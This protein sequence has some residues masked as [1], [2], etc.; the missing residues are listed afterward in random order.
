MGKR[1]ILMCAESSHVDSGF[2][3]YTRNLLS[4]LYQTGKYEIAE[5][6]AYRS[7]N[8]KKGFPWRIYP[9]VPFEG[10]PQDVEQKEIVNRYKSNP[11][12]AFG[13][14]AFEAACY[15][16]KPDIVFDVRDFW[17]LNFP[18]VSP[19]RPFFH[20]FVA[21][22][23]D[24]APQ[25][26]EW[27]QTFANADTISGH[28]Q[29]GVDYLA[30]TN[31]GMNLV[32]PVNDAVNT[33]VFLP[34]HQP[35]EIIKQELGFNKDDI[36]IGS[37]MRNQKRKLI[38]N[39]IK[40]AKEVSK[41]VPN[42]K[43]YLHTSYP[44]MN[45]WDLPSLLVEH[46]AMDLVYMTYKCQA[47]GAH[48]ASTFKD[49]NTICHKCGKHA[50]VVCSVS[51]GVNEQELSNIFN[52]FDVYLQYAICEGFGIPPVEAAACGV[53]VV[54]IDHGA[55]AEIGANIG[56]DIIPVASEFRELETNA[57][58]VYPD[59]NKCID[60]LVE[61]CK[62]IPEM[63]FIEKSKVR[64]QTRE[65]LMSNY[66]WD[67]T[68]KTFENILDN[69]KLTGVQGKWDS[70]PQKSRT[71]VKVPQLPSHRKT[72][73]FITNYI[74]NT[75]H[76]TKTSTIQDIIKSLCL[77]YKMNGPNMHPFTFEDAVKSLEGLMHN[78]DLWEQVRIGEIDFPK[79]LEYIIKYPERDHLK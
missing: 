58:R 4:R 63:S 41:Q 18:E 8:M 26:K 75:P 68:A 67:K 27:L 1:R 43:L 38:P 39:V 28:T 19:F 30:S 22:T 33:D 54:T 7:P 34:S 32:E 25:R 79:P 48:F 59:D 55:M 61:K 5:L 50:A 49:S 72:I 20:W 52:S 42:V 47:C 56:A 62:K 57:D 51:N 12:N 60:V 24:S 74:M 40:I 36:I 31:M 37:V 35:K 15:D 53:P 71:E 23:I 16:F 17:M 65:K 46:D 21:P 45:G 2:G 76:L 73:N 66:S 44:D 3:N 64:D 14:W 70:A 69:I 13:V 77:G 10:G 11:A 9:V 6:S 78:K 29:W